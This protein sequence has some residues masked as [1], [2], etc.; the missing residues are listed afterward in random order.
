MVRELE[1]ESFLFLPLYCPI[2]KVGGPFFPQG[3]SF[4]GKSPYPSSLSFPFNSV[5]LSSVRSQERGLWGSTS[6]SCP[7]DFPGGLVV[8]SLSADAGD[9]GSVRASGGSHMPCGS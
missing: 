7:R 8:E 3:L 2:R 5:L 1:T 4:R 9:M 6:R